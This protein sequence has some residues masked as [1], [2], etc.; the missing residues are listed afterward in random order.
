[1]CTTPV[2]QAYQAELS[3]LPVTCKRQA[4][5]PHEFKWQMLIRYHEPQL[6][7]SEDYFSQHAVAK[8]QYLQRLLNKINVEGLKH[9]A[10]TFRRGV[11]CRVPALE[12]DQSPTSKQ[13][14]I[15][16]QMGGQNCHVDVNFDDGVTW[17]ARIRLEDPLLPPQGVQSHIFL[18][19]IATLKFLAK[20]SV[21]APNVYCYELEGSENIVGT[22]YVLMEKMPGKPLDWNGAGVDQRRKVMEQLADI[23]LE[24]E[25]HPLQMT[26]SI[27]PSVVDSSQPEAAAFAQVPYFK[28]PGEALGPFSTLREAYTAVLTQQL[29]TIENHEISSLPIDNALVFMW[30]LSMVDTLV[31]SSTSKSGPFYLKHQDDKGDHILVDDNYNITGIIDWEFASAEAKE[32]AFSSPCMMWPVG[33]FYEGHNDLS[34]DEIC[35]ADILASRGRKDLSEMVMQGRRW[36]R[37]LFFLGG[38]PHDKADFKALFQGLRRTFT[39][40]DR[41]EICTYEEWKEKSLEAYSED[42]RLQSLLREDPDN[43][44][45]K[46]DGKRCS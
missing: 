32:L 26:G 15:S 30:Q 7:A 12:N 1:M 43:P 28:T 40:L 29:H 5:F 31:D 13:D 33:T 45:N 10:S 25:R 27:A 18:S 36:Q 21:P 4:Y 9:T 39:P 16:R 37:F 23:Y 35:F 2:F 8:E 42:V 11:P 14:V 19:E 17:I 6:E 3:S 41:P 24:L 38:I 46:S 34:N 20:T 22:P 44:R